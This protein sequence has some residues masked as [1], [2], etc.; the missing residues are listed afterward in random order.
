MARLSPGR[1]KLVSRV[2]LICYGSVVNNTRTGRNLAAQIVLEGRCLA[3][4][5][6]YIPGLTATISS[7]Y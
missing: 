7:G 6:P 3:K 4:E 1:F 2:I 5:T